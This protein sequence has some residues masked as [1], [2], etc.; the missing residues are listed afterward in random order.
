MH[1]STG[2]ISLLNNSS[3][4]NPHFETLLPIMY[5]GW[6]DNSAGYNELLAMVLFLDMM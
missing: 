5:N 3:Q 4:Q 2:T 6:V 1:K